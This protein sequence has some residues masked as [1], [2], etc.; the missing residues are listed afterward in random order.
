MKKLLYALF[1]ILL[2]AGCE[3]PDNGPEHNLVLDSNQKA[4]FVIPY[5]GGNAE[6]VFT[7]SLAWKA[8]VINQ[9]GEQGWITIDKTAG[10]GGVVIERIH[11]S[12]TP[13]DFETPRE[14]IVRLV[15]GPVAVDISVSQEPKVISEPVPEPEHPEPEVKV[16]EITENS[17][18]VESEGGE[19]R[20]EVHFNV[21]YEVTVDVD[22]IRE[23]ETKAY[24]TKI[25]TFVVEPN[26][27]AQPR[28]AMIS[29]CGNGECIP[30]VVEQEG[31]TTDEPGTDPDE[32]GTDPDQPGTEEKVFELTERYVMMPAEGG[33]IMIEVLYNV[34]YEVVTDVDWI[35]EVETRA[36]ESKIHHFII[37]PNESM[38]LRSANI[39]FI[40]DGDPLQFVVDQ[41]GQESSDPDPDQ[42]DPDPDPD[43]PGPDPEQPEE[44][45]F[46]LLE[47]SVRL[48]NEG[49]QFSV[50]F[51]YYKSITY[52]SLPP[53]ISEIGGVAGGI[54]EYRFIAEP[55]YGNDRSVTLE[56]Q[57]DGKT[58]RF[59]VQQEGSSMELLDKYVELGV[60]GGEFSVRVNS[61]TNYTIETPDWITELEGADSGIHNFVAAENS[62]EVRTAKI[63]FRFGPLENAVVVS[64]DGIVY[65]LDVDMPSISARAEGTS[66][67]I[68]VNVTS[69]TA[70]TVSSDSQW[71]SVSVASG[72]EDGSFDV[73]V[74]PNETE[75]T[76]MAI[77]TVTAASKVKTIAVLQEPM[78]DESGD[79]LWKTKEFHHRSLV[80]RFT[81]DW[82]G[83]CPQMAEALSHAEKAMP[84]KIESISVHG[85][86]SSLACEA[87]L[88]L[89]NDYR[90]GSYPTGIV[91]GTTV[92]ANNSSTKDDILAAVRSTESKYKTYTG[93]SWTSS[94]SGSNI[95]LDLSAY[96]KKAGSY[97]IT[98]LLLEDGVIASQYD[99]RV[100]NIN[101][102]K[103]S[104]IIRGA[105]SDASGDSFEV[106]E[107]NVV[108]NFTY[109]LTI[110]SGSNAANM[111]VL[112]YIMREDS[113]TSSYYVDNSLSCPVG[114]DQPLSI[115][116]NSWGG[117][118][119]G[120]NPG[121]DIIL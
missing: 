103:H 17:A 94:V 116:N 102:Y 56:F 2:F 86:N 111:S 15:S 47:N 118:N 38:S 121:D 53:W 88:A 16:F 119:E 84:D 108:K 62:G 78:V 30:F 93:T 72:N 54:W 55:N 83:Y 24:D 4:H 33:D 48:S 11:I 106:S 19:I 74:L 98:A 43:Q 25:H 100:G 80:M 73:T 61:N 76:R 6:V 105:F 18:V 37:D 71:C 104:R 23:V 8:E 69:N 90:I 21:E 5:A 117:G 113:N 57:S 52:N 51:R 27:L 65:E 60:E 12:V 97:K 41:A 10:D 87:S 85:V 40:T 22:W 70:W 92:I 101:S 9:I 109:T 36:H 35:H 59:E 110:P 67:P 95:T 68:T 26:E 115:V 34:D 1:S 120:I 114:V 91:D 81:A 66:D 77:I 7:S 63:Y 3:R 64:Q 31:R 75:S 107:D 82:C 14:A 44:P 96:I 50:K 46:E 112:V 99:N 79:D 45:V 39:L 49:G 32:P 28:N 13:N 42:P 29:F 20:I 58:L 89:V